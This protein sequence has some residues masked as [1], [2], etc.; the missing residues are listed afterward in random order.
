[1]IFLVPFSSI[2]LLPP[3]FHRGKYFYLFL[4]DNNLSVSETE[5]FRLFKV[6]Q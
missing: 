3:V 1:M 4:Q 2:F 6:I 5:I